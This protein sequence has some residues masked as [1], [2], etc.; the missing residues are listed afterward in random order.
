MAVERGPKSLHEHNKSLLY[1]NRPKFKDNLRENIYV[2]RIRTDGVT[3]EKIEKEQLEKVI[4]Q[5]RRNAKKKLLREY[6][7]FTVSIFITAFILLFLEN[8]LEQ[9]F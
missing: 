5:I 3:F 1:S 2:D 7:I 9:V 6:K 8:Y 4:A